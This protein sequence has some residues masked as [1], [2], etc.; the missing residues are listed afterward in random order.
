[1]GLQTDAEY[2]TSDGRI[3]LLIRTTRFVYIMEFKLDSTAEVAMSQIDSKEYCLPWACDGRTIFS[4]GV[5]FSSVSR[6]LE[7][8]IIVDGSETTPQVPPKYPTSTPQVPSKVLE[9]LKLLTDEPLAVT[10]IMRQLSLSDRKS[11]RK[12]YLNDAIAGGWVSAVYPGVPNHPRQAYRL[13][14]LGKVCCF[15]HENG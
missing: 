15:H 6:R 13:T 5:N 12:T 7:D 4:I 14:E 9:L 11:F 10:D 3:D 8:W 1:M 2:R